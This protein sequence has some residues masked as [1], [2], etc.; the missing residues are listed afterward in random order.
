MRLF[1]EE[2]GVHEWTDTDS[3]E[4]IKLRVDTLTYP[5]NVRDLWIRIPVGG[6]GFGAFWAA[7]FKTRSEAEAHDYTSGANGDAGD[8][9]G[10]SDWRDNNGVIAWVNGASWPS[11]ATSMIFTNNAAVAPDLTGLVLEVSGDGSAPTSDQDGVWGYMAAPEVL[12]SE[13]IQWALE[14][15]MG[16]GQAL[17]DFSAAR[18]EIVPGGIEV[19][20]RAP[21][22]VGVITEAE[23]EEAAAGEYAL[24]VNFQIIVGTARKDLE[25]VA[26]DVLAHAGNVRSILIDQEKTLDGVALETVIS[27]TEG[28]SSAIGDGKELYTIATLH[29]FARFP[30][31]T[32]DV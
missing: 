12:V 32:T 11:D 22:I 7:A 28:P 27:S 16:S 9:L 13:K 20:S 1:Y 26:T 3:L 24:K 4:V 15:Y 17:E 6:A 18:L 21:N 29:G 31:M 25:T 23:D 2:K 14:Q 5:R 10:D 30:R 8:F 19:R